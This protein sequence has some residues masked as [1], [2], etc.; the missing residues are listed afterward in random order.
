MIQDLGHFG[1]LAQNGN[2]EEQG[3]VVG[4][5][6]IAEGKKPQRKEEEDM[7]VWHPGS[8]GPQLAAHGSGKTPGKSELWRLPYLMPHKEADL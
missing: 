2:V 5:T 4:L 8:S 1:F 3:S 7:P 6:Y